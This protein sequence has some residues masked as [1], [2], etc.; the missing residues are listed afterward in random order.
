M[1]ARWRWVLGGA[2]LALVLALI[3]WTAQRW[4]RGHAK[5]PPLIDAAEPRI[6]APLPP[7]DGATAWIDTRPLDAKRLTGRVT[8][9][10][11]WS[12]ADLPST[13]VVSVAMAW[14]GRYAPLGV[15]VIFVHVPRF[16][17]AQDSAFVARDARRLGIDAPIVVD[18]E[19]RVWGRYGVLPL[20]ALV[21]AD[22]HGVVRYARGG[23]R[24]LFQA[25]QALRGLLADASPGRALPL[26]IL[27]SPDDEPGGF[28]DATPRVALVPGGAEGALQSAQ[29]GQAHVFA[30]ALRAQV[31]S[32][33]G[34]PAPVGEWF[35]SGEGLR[36]VRGTAA[37]YLALRYHG[38][39]VYAVI[40][41]PP[42]PPVRVWVL[43]D[44]RWLPSAEA[45][46]DVRAGG[47]G[48]SSL[49]VSEPRMYHVVHGADGESHVLK[50]QPDRP[51]V[52]IYELCFDGSK[53]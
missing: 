19:Q 40:S 28:G 4:V 20:P 38:R 5:G 11:F 8:V 50:L 36:S 35:V 37:D 22:H 23:P 24:G 47:N 34:V 15:R 12:G 7:L 18:S 51:G 44:E 2:A 10:Q 30:P 6:G 31:E 16:T 3:A 33:D 39:D 1:G 53:P 42:G 14:A 9:L 49:A 25:E 43:R 26:P 45:G 48:A 46:A 13:R 27:R 32:T 21:M 29:A 17:F 52:E 41:A